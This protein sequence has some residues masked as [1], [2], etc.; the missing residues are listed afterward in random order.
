MALGSSGTAVAVELYEP[1]GS[2]NYSWGTMPTD[3]NYTDQLL[4]SEMGLL[5]CGALV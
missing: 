3:H 5:S 4:D 1:Y 2:P